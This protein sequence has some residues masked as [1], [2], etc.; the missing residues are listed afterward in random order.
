MPL[1]LLLKGNTVFSTRIKVSNGQL[2]K[3]CIIGVV[4]KK[5]ATKLH[6][7]LTLRAQHRQLVI[8]QVDYEEV[9]FATAL[10][11]NNLAIMIA[12]TVSVLDDGDLSFNGDILDHEIDIHDDN[13][14][15]LDM[16]FD[17][18]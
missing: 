15:Y 18:S 17:K 1:Y 12:S 5:E 10:R 2:S 11:L 9:Q 4:D 7:H 13:R 6:N 3:T 8:E 14:L 16:I